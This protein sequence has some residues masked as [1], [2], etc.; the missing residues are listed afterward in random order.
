MSAALAVPL[1]LV[2][3]CL[4]MAAYNP[5]RLERR[6]RRSQRTADKARA[7]VRR[8]I[9]AI[10]LDRCTG[11]E[12]CIEVC[13]T[14]VLELVEH[15]AQV[16]RQETCIE[17]RQCAQACPTS[18]L[19]MHRQGEE[20]PT[21]R[22]PD[23]TPTFETAVPGQY[24]IGEVAGRPLVKNGAN[25][26]R[27]V[28]EH[29]VGGGLVGQGGRGDEADHPV[30]VV[31]VGAG[32]AGLSAAL[33]CRYHGLS[34]IV[35]E[36]ENI[37]AS[38][39]A[40][41]PRGKTFLAEPVD[42]RN[43]SFLPVW[44]TTKEQLI[45]A[46][47]HMIEAAGLDVRI[48]VGV[49]RVS[50]R[51]DGVFEVRTAAGALFARRAVLAIGTRGKPRTL[52]VPGESLVKVATM[53][54]D[55][56]SHRGQSVLV[57]GGGDSA[58]EAACALAGAGA[59]RVTLSYRGRSFAR[60]RKRNR[61]AIDRLVALGPVELLLGS[62]V[63]E[64]TDDGVVIQLANGQSIE[65]HAVYVLIGADAPLRW[66]ERCGVR[67]VERPHRQ[68][69]AA[70]DALLVGLGVEGECPADAEQAL[71]R[72]L[73]R[74]ASVRGATRRGGRPT[75]LQGEAPVATLARSRSPAV[76][77]LASPRRPGIASAATLVSGGGRRRPPSPV[78]PAPSPSSPGRGAGGEPTVIIAWGS[79]RGGVGVEDEPAFD[80]DEV[81]ADDDYTLVEDLAVIASPGRAR[82]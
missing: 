62:H 69:M 17:C 21:L 66:L 32:P 53:L 45:A 34:A 58:L 7:R 60:A 68:P 46:W 59:A 2:A 57:V 13:P 41:Y 71:W 33:T 82:R 3:C 5:I 43:L 76:V 50:R 37:L 29:M 19:V 42:C 63:T 80:T 44:D 49:D 65:N 52:G 75:G 55:A 70:T 39:V 72:V 1:I 67:T 18:A 31:I 30:N 36:K 22:T 12:A 28:V 38:T 56:D 35:L 25:L 11:C 14:Y 8:W 16:A 81:I 54:D 40:R 74:A 73:G 47:T 64:I 20:P 4:A 61:D 6:R 77:E 27:L 10:N 48:G 78:G 79:L 26:G 51:D 15:K 23:I 24:L 9:H